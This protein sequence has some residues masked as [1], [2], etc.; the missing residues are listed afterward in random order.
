MGRLL[1]IGLLGLNAPLI[2]LVGWLIFDD[3]D[4]FCDGLAFNETWWNCAKAFAFLI[5]WGAIVVAEYFLIRRLFTAEP[6]GH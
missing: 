1:F 5:V 4:E 6:Q 2:Y 3:L